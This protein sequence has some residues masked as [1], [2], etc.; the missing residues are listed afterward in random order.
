MKKIVL[1]IGL[2]FWFAATVDAALPQDVLAHSAGEWTWFAHV[3]KIPNVVPTDVPGSN[4]HTE[5]F[6]LQNAPGQQWQPLP[7]LPGRAVALAGRSSQ[8]AVLMSDGQW[9]TLWP[10]GSASGQPL[11]AEGHIKTLADDGTHLWA[12]GS[13]S[14]GITAA[15]LAVTRE[16]AVTQR[17]GPLCRSISV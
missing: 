5:V 7:T 17:L 4:E 15:D 9:L 8:L 3:S 13:V 1:L 11:P 2:V 12:I 6:A 14:G 16:A 10:D